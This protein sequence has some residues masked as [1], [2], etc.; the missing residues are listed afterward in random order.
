[1]IA[2]DGNPVQTSSRKPKGGLYYVLTLGSSG[3]ASET[4]APLVIY[5]QHSVSL[6]SALLSSMLNSFSG[7]KTTQKSQVFIYP[8]SG[9]WKY[10]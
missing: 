8:I 1:M 9:Q 10:P 3:A 2:S 4:T 6:L 5:Y 7:R